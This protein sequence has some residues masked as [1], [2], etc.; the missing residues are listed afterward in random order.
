MKKSNIGECFRFEIGALL[1]SDNILKFS[2]SLAWESFGRAK[3]FFE[4]SSG[5]KCD[6]AQ[7]KINR[8][9]SPDVTTF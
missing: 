7:N 4:N 8:P 3:L 5:H 9:L 6:M 1:F 2:F